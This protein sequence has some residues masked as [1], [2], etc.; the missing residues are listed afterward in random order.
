[1]SVALARYLLA[2]RFTALSILTT[3]NINCTF[4]GA[5]GMG[6]AALTFLCDMSWE[7]L[8]V[9]LKNMDIWEISWKGYKITF[10]LNSSVSSF[11]S[12]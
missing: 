5:V 10:A 11:C 4:R 12:S 8:I 9:L 2:L 7:N 1:M 3:R 6:L